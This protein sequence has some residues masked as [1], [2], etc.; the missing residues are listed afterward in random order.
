MYVLIFWTAKYE[1]KSC[2]N[3]MV[4][5]YHILQLIFPF[6]TWFVGIYFNFQGQ[7]SLWNQYLPHS[8]SKSY[9]INSIESCSSRSISLTKGTFQFLWN[10]QLQ[11][12]LIFSEEIIQYSRTFTPQVQTSWNQADEPLVLE[13]FPKRPRTQSEASWFRVDLIDTNTTNKQ[14]SFIDRWCDLELLEDNMKKGPN[15]FYILNGW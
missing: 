3:W 8:K 10:F 4:K 13:S 12:H 5:C 9:Q 2:L 1:R 14:P 7:K 6:K 11:F 15:I